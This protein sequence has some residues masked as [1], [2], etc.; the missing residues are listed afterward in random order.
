MMQNVC[1]PVSSASDV[2]WHAQVS[3]DDS[4]APSPSAAPAVAS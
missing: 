1:S 2:G 4:P 3:S